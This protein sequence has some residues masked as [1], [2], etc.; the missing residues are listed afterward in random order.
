MSHSTPET[1]LPTAVRQGGNRK[2][3]T[4]YLLQGPYC[5]IQLSERRTIQ[6]EV[7]VKYLWSQSIPTHLFQ[8]PFRPSFIRQDGRGARRMASERIFDC[9][10]LN[11]GTPLRAGWNSSTIT[12]GW[13]GT[14]RD[15]PYIYIPPL[16]SQ[17]SLDSP[18]FPKWFP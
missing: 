3:C 10:P 4:T 1:P 2:G 7:Q 8:P 11:Y 12:Q 9:H 5:N 16:Y 13:T 18:R 17:C 6:L 14:K 15:S